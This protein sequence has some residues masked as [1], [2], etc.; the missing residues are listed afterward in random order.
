MIQIAHELIQILE[1]QE[2][3]DALAVA[4]LLYVRL[5][6]PQAYVTVTGETSTGKSSL[7]NGLV[8]RQ[9]LPVAARPTT[10]TVTHVVCREEAGDMFF[11]IYRDATQEQIS[12][13]Q[14]LALS[15]SPEDDLLRLQV[16]TKPV[17]EKFLGLQIF[18]T[19]GYNATLAKHEE[20]L[21]AFLPQSDV[22][23]FVVGY[24]T[25]FGQVDQDLLEVI[26]SSISYTD[27]IPVIM[28]VNRAPQGISN[29]DG[30]VAEIL[31]NARDCLNRDP[32]LIVIES[33][34]VDSQGSP[35]RTPV[36]PLSLPLWNVVAS[37][38]SKPSNLMSVQKRLHQLLKELT[39]EVMTRVERQ[40]ILLSAKAD[41]LREINEQV[42]ELVSARD[43]SLAAV[44]QMADKL[45]TQLPKTV[46]RLAARLKV[47]MAA[48]IGISNKWLGAHD[49]AEW[50]TI[51]AMPF[52]V[53]EIAK[54]IEEQISQE[55]EMLNRKLEEI[56]NTAV[57][58]ILNSAHLKSDA[59]RSFAENLTGRVL[60][61]IGGSAV[62]NVLCGLGGVGGA[63]AGAGNIV[64]MAVS[65][66]GRV[67]GKT[68]ER[69]VYADI[70]KL[71][72]KGFLQKLNFVLDGVVEGIKYL[73]GVKTWQNK[74]TIKVKEAIDTWT[75]DVIK[76]LRENQIPT[77]QSTNEVGVRQ[78]YDDLLVNKLM[79]KDCASTEITKSLETVLTLKEK[80]QTLLNRL[81]M[82]NL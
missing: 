14:F 52:S 57:K 60:K 47:K 41:D 18:D 9:L 8:Q 26:R 74:L 17:D 37:E 28:V 6:H 29:D 56:A 4:R 33:A 15:M 49:C 61:R 38:I 34:T 11:A 31:S 27:E 78:Y 7:V 42:L 24:R 81:E 32:Q 12:G 40:E 75:S 22:I 51:H 35:S 63:A 53:R 25:G 67:F 30:R 54:S 16:R 55:L 36:I 19:P 43:K 70:G 5:R 45:A 76:D 50:I 58:K 65:R 21:R 3:G 46:E 82:L 62:Q 68:F 10:A 2:E 66:I 72:T 69:K 13:D 39:I 79:H 1:Q 73:Y 80:L 77:I 44:Q 48:E 71:F 20:V 64:K 59:V 23:I